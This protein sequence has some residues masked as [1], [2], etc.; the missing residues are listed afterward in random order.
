MAA[1]LVAAPQDEEVDALLDGFQR[2]GHSSE[3]VQIGRMT[4]A[5]VPS[6]DAI[7]ATGGHG[8]A[9]FAVQTQHLIGHSPDAQRLL[10]VG[11]AGGLAE[12]LEV[13]DV[14][15][16]TTT[17]EHDYVLRFV[18]KP[19]P[20]HPPD[21]DLLQE[22]QEVTRA[23]SFPFCVHFAPVAS[24]DEDIVDPQRAQNLR[25]TTGALCAAW[26]GSGGARAALFND[27]AFLEV[28]GIT[29]GAD[30]DAPASYQ[31]HLARVMSN[32]AD[33]LVRWHRPK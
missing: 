17:V 28:R 7:V 24:G 3:S 32:I 15:V 33:L 8:K 13:G 1:T 16:G 20:R 30:A 11:A 2:R 10:C 14:V 25:A 21:A 26:E 18:R 22:V 12:P 5:A 23:H 4:C 19:L 31:E 27:L 29:D 9:Q 6:L